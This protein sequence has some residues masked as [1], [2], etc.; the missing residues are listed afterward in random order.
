MRHTVKMKFEDEVVKS[1]EHEGVGYEVIRQTRM[2]YPSDWHMAHDY[3]GR[4]KYSY[5]IR[6]FNADN[7]RQEY[8]YST[9]KMRFAYDWFKH[10]MD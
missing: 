9:V 2:I 5:V 10:R 7:P 6:S 8:Q 4:K 1:C 3:E